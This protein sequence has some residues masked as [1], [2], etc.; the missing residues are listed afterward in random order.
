MKR[1]LAVAILVAAAWVS[2]GSADGGGA[3][4]G[5]SF[6]GKGIQSRRGDVRY[7]TLFAGPGSVVEAV[8]I[9]GGAVVRSRYL[10]GMFGIPFV[11]YD[12]SA[13]GL[14]HDGR[15]LVL[16]SVPPNLNRPV[17]RFV[18]LDPR[19][20]RIKARLRLR[21]NF[22]FDAVSAGGSLMYLIQHLGAP[23][24]G[25]YAVRALNLNTRRLYSGAIVDRREPDEKMTGIPVTR[26]DSGDGNW[27]YTLYSRTNKNPFVHALDTGHRRAFCVDLPFRPSTRW[28]ASARMRMSSDG[29]QLILFTGRKVRAT[30]DTKSFE[31]NP[32]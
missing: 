26:V 18:V 23:T 31:V 27:A 3:S 24:S 20:F 7:V 28:I 16:A 13:G 1:T 15:R 10:G 14:S 21:G 6:G 30:V 19:T 9:R 25:R 29:R 2:T 17:T 8:R 11:A 4:P 5:I 32:V 12:G 22:A